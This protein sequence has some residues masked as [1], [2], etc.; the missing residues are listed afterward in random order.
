M[1]LRVPHRAAS[2]TASPSGHGARLLPDHGPLVGRPACS[3]TPRGTTGR[4][5]RSTCCCSTTQS[6]VGRSASSTCIARLP[7]V[8]VL[9]VPVILSRRWRPRRAPP[10][11]RSSRPCTPR[12]GAHGAAPAVADRRPRRVA[13]LTWRRRGHG[14][15]REPRSRPVRV[16]GRP[17]RSRLSRAGAVERAGGA[18]GGARRG[19][20]AC[21]TRSPTRSATRASS[22][23][24]GC[25]PAGSYVNADG[26]PVEL[27]EPLGPSAWP[28]SSRT[29][30]TAVAAIVHDASLA[31]ERDL[32]AAVGAAAPAHARERAA[33][34][35][36]ARKGRGAPRSA[37]PRRGGG[38][39]GTPPAGA[40]PP[41]RRPAAARVDGAEAAAG[42]GTRGRRPEGTER[43]ARRRAAQELDAALE[44]LRELARGHPPGG[45]QRP[46]AGRGA[47]GARQARAGAG[48]GGGHA[49]RALPRGRGGW[50]PTS[51][52][53]RRSRTSPSTRPPRTRHRRRR[54]RQRP[55]G[56][57]G[58][59]RRRGRGGPRRAARA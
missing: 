19:A 2:Q 32:I 23:S 55:R 40:Q 21:A 36:A 29:T 17:V 56:R 9:C 33:G 27:P 30:A 22:S 1:L 20:A 44:E 37:P 57:G 10:S 50:P 43:A 53:R 13:Q 58:G 47:R 42:A 6:L 15:P 25:P 16:P 24:T 54:A 12:G 7:I 45:A 41:R 59:R 26:H 51:S 4:A 35:R 28:R 11:G 49:R 38:T 34:R 39:R 8:A 52:W 48:G 3:T 18:A 14:R 31:D 46:R 5:T